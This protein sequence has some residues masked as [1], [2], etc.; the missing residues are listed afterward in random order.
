MAIIGKVKIKYRT[1]DTSQVRSGRGDH[2]TG[3]VKTRLKRLLRAD[4]DLVSD[5]AGRPFL[6]SFQ[7][8]EVVLRLFPDAFV[9]A[10][11]AAGQKVTREVAEG[12]VSR[13]AQTAR[14]DD[15]MAGGRGRGRRGQSRFPTAHGKW[16]EHG[17]RTRPGPG[18]AT[19]GCRPGSARKKTFGFRPWPPSLIMAL[20]RAAAVQR[21]R[22]APRHL[23]HHRH[24]HRPARGPG[25]AP[26]PPGPVRG[27]DPVR[28]RHWPA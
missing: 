13:Q 1:V 21:H 7:C 28:Q 27:T 14:G 19:A 2:Q 24:H 16:A 5:P 20:R 11:A 6:S 8:R 17:C 3:Q 12:L 25:P 22:R 9:L 18:A 23:F 15:D 4:F 26:P 10:I